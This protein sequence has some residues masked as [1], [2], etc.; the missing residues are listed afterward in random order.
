[1]PYMPSYY[2]PPRIYVETQMMRRRDA[3][4]AAERAAR[5]QRQKIAE[6]IEQHGEHMSEE[7]RGLLTGLAETL[8]TIARSV[9]GDRP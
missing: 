8:Q 7:G 4:R 6:A 3:L 1:M 2:R 9:R 5:A